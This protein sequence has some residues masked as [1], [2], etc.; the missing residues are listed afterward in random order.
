MDISPL[1]KALAD[2]ARLRIVE[3]LRRPDQGCC[4]A[5]D[6]VCACDIEQLLGLSQPA[7][8]H[9]MKILIQAGLVGAEKQG[10][11]MYYRLVPGAFAGLVSALTPY[12]QPP[13]APN[14]A[15]AA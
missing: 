7:I 2:P 6:R 14:R 5:D 9:H 1:L 11:W 13:A 4:V 8:S 12:A 3:F 10:R 15:R